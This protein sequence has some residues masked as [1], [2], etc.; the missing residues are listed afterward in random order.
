MS[1]DDGWVQEA[2]LA[3]GPCPQCASL[4]VRPIS[5]GMPDADSYHRLQGVVVFAGCC[6]PDQPWHYCCGTCGASWGR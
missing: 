1:N 4:D 6:V 5:Y 3:A 2:R